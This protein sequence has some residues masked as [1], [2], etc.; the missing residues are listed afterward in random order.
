MEFSAWLIRSYGLSLYDFR[1]LDEDNTSS[2]VVR[3]AFGSWSKDARPEQIA[4]AIKD[5]EAEGFFVL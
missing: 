1:V 4:K 5:A 3:E 2:K